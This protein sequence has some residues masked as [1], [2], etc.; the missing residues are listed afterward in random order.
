[1]LVWAFWTRTPETSKHDNREVSDVVWRASSV[2]FLLVELVS[3]H[4]VHEVI[5]ANFFEEGFRLRND[6]LDL[7]ADVGVE[8]LA[9]R[10]RVGS[11]LTFGDAQFSAS[12]SFHKLGISQLRFDWLVRYMQPAPRTR[13]Q[14]FPGKGRVGSGRVWGGKYKWNSKRSKLNSKFSKLNY[15][16]SKLNVGMAPT[17]IPK[18]LNTWQLQH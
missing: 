3:L 10:A 17:L 11:L 14:W 1:M 6:I 16:L 8:F 12:N 7:G 4:V 5:G 13:H 18:I 15:A 2:K 9:R